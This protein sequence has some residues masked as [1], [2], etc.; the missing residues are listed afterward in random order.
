LIASTSVTSGILVFDFLTLADIGARQFGIEMV[1]HGFRRTRRGCQITFDR[2]IHAV[3]AFAGDFL[4]LCLTR[5]SQRTLRSCRNCCANKKPRRSQLAGA[6]RGDTDWSACM[7]NRHR[8]SQVVSKAYLL[9][10]GRRKILKQSAVHCSEHC[11]AARFASGKTKS[12]EA[13]TCG[14]PTHRKTIAGSRKYSFTSNLSFLVLNMKTHVYSKNS[15]R[16]K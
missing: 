5:G 8:V 9:R 11:Q 1:E 12:D 7:K 4:L 10:G 6:K 15:H 2:R 3:L 13:R 16:T 14:S